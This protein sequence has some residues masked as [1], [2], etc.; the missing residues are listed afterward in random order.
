MYHQLKCADRCNKGAHHAHALPDCMVN[1]NTPVSNQH[2]HVEAHTPARTR[3]YGC[4]NTC[5]PGCKQVA[6]LVVMAQAGCFVPAEFM[7]LCPFS[8]LLTRMGTGDSIETNSS[9]FMLECQVST[10]NHPHHVSLATIVLVLVATIRASEASPSSPT[11]HHHQTP[12]LPPSP[13]LSYLSLL[14]VLPSSLQSCYL[15]LSHPNMLPLL[16]AFSNAR[17]C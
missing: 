12:P 5:T 2:T 14:I 13:L 9:S 11:H 6:L 15:C 8:C 10:C 16:S 4:A 3:T 7:A 1:A 17:A